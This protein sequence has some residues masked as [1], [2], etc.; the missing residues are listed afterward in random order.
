MKSTE[1]RLRALE[2]LA[3]FKPPPSVRRVIVDVGETLEAVLEREG[4]VPYD[5][6]E[7]DVIAHV[8]IAPGTEAAEEAAAAVEPAIPPADALEAEPQDFD[9]KPRTRDPLPNS[10][11]DSDD[12]EDRYE[13]RQGP[14]MLGYR[15]R[16][17]A[18]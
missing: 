4:I 10:D 12:R 13:P 15:A 1:K 17:S 2:A 7:I 8:I 18:E 16:G 3:N 5:G 11:R 6:P 9:P 14:W